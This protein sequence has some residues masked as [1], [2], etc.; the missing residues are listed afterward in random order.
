MW[1]SMAFL[2]VVR[3]GVYLRGGVERDSVEK[4]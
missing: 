1:F 3:E 2:S 4:V